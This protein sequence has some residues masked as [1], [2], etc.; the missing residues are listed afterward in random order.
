MLG[1][2][3]APALDRSVDQL[4][5]PPTR[6]QRVLRT[7]RLEETW[8]RAT[9]PTALVV[10]M[11][12]F[13][14]I[15]PNFATWHNVNAML[16]DAAIP[17]LL[18][19]GMTF[20]V[21]LAGIDLSMAATLALASVV[22]GLGYQAGW[23]LPVSCLLAVGVGVVVGLAN[24][25]FVG[26]V[27]IPDMIVTLGTM[28]LVQGIGLVVSKGIPVPVADDTLRAIA[29]Q[30]A[31]PLRYNILIVLVIGVLLHVLLTH[32]AVGTHLLAV[33]DNMDA[34]K[35]MGLRVPR[36][37]LAGYVIG[38]ALAGTAAIFLVLYVGSTQPATN[39]DY[40]M[41]AVAATV[42]GGTSLFGG[43]A[44]VWGPMLGAILLT[45]VQ[46]G[47]TMVGVEAFYEPAVVGIVVLAAA[48]L[49]RGRK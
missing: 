37:K 42:L 9:A 29:S 21:M 47:L 20:A 15:S 5:A 30:S 22:F 49:M 24:G 11:I 40:V 45:V 6:L 25:F 14:L 48:T 27:R 43:R 36:I 31:G 26:R 1:S 3:P 23:G 19:M 17:V 16:A 18:A 13:S 34:S 39:T 7:A 41:K 8:T 12:V 10:A 33:G 32:T 44:T 38:G 28:G 46:T 4:A 2:A 35:A